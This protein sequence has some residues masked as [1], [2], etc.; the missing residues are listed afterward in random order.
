MKDTMKEKI[1]RDPSCTSQQIFEEVEDDEESI[2]LRKRLACAFG[3]A[4]T[5]DRDLVLKQLPAMKAFYALNP[6]ILDEV[7]KLVKD[8]LE[9]IGLDP[10]QMHFMY[11]L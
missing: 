9:L 11:H 3:S 5:I 4:N 2:M 7:K 10:Q 6:E 8:G 1:V